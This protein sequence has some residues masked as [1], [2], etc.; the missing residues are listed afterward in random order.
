MSSSDDCDCAD[1]WEGISFVDVTIE[2]D[3]NP[4]CT[5]VPGVQP[6]GANPLRLDMISADRG[7]ECGDTTIDSFSVTFEDDTYCSGVGSITVRDGP[8]AVR[9][10]AFSFEVDPDSCSISTTMSNDFGA[11]GTIEIIPIPGGAG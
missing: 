9:Q 11:T 8:F 1:S 3:G 4:P 6:S 7:I 5:F 10:Y 2:E